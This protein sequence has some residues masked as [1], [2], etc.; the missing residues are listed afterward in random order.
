MGTDFKSVPIF[1]SLPRWIV[2]RRE[3]YIGIQ[4]DY[5]GHIL[6]Y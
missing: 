5:W 3:E 6:I 2:G 1:F 4:E